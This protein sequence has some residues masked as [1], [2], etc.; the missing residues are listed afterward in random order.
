MGVFTEERKNVRIR[1]IKEIINPSSTRPKIGGA[2]G[3]IR[4]ACMVLF[5]GASA[6]FIG[7]LYVNCVLCSHSVHTFSLP[8][9]Q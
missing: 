3:L 4:G 7:G 1:F 8:K 5:G 2:S 6:G 9:E